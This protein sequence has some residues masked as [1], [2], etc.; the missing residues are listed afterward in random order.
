[1]LYPAELRAHQNAFVS[2]ETGVPKAL[3]VTE[4]DPLMQVALKGAKIQG[5]NRLVK[6]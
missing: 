2:P 4:I 3:D 1:M 5:K 6:I